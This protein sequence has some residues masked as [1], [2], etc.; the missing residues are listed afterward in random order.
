MFTTKRRLV[1]ILI[2][3]LSAG[4]SLSSVIIA[5][6]VDLNV[7]AQDPLY[8]D[9]SYHSRFLYDNGTVIQNLDFDSIPLEMSSRAICNVTL[10]GMPFGEFNVTSDGRYIDPILGETHNFTIFWLHIVAPDSMGSEMTVHVGENYSIFDP[11]GVLGAPN[12][13]YTLFI[14]ENHVYW[15]EDPSLHG[16]QY[17]LKFEIRDLND[18]KVGEGELDFTSGILFRLN[19]G[20]GNLR[21]L[22][23]IDT[24]YVISRNR[25][26][27]WPW[28]IT[29]AIASPLIVFMYLFYRRKE[30]LQIALNTA[31]LV[32][33]GSAAFIIDI[34]IDVW[35]YATIPLGFTGNLIIHGTMIGILI[36]YVMWQK[37]GVKWVIPAILELLFLGA[38][39]GYT[40]DSYVPHLTAFI[41]VILTWLCLVWVTGY[42]RIP[43]KRKFGKLISEVV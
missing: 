9:S 16:A 30:P 13:T 17:S 12:R 43:S 3:I 26:A 5:R 2:V 33:I 34:M 7:N 21:T 42:E 22:K 18:V 40:G 25:L 15:A 14:T 23:L 27:G 8:F 28:T 6:L 20:A 31:T 24:N 32:A 35:M 1:I 38:M 4:F 29:F 11:V 36:V 41:G 10:N 37:V 19:I 39:V